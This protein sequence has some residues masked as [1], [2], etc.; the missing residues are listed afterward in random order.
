AY[1]KG[2]TLSSTMGPGVKVN[3]DNAAAE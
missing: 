1:M 2:I 3:V